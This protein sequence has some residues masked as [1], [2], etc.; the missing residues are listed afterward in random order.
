[1]AT[2]AS[3]TH[4]SKSLAN[5]D[6]MK[7][8]L[9]MKRLVSKDQSNSKNDTAEKGA[10]SKFYKENNFTPENNDAMSICS[11]K[12]KL[13]SI[14]SDST[15]NKSKKTSAQLSSEEKPS[16]KMF[17]NKQEKAFKQLAAIV[18]GFTLCF[19]PY[20]VVFLIVAMCEECI[21]EN[22]FTASVWLGY[23]N[24]TIN[25]FLYAI[26]NKRFF[27]KKSKQIQRTHTLTKTINH[28]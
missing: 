10:K 26:S 3:A 21:S 24:S 15:F 1:M 12:S 13:R 16:R 5:I 11:T 7:G 6:L 28:L 4:R 27:K 14:K 9:Q 18:I 8:A 25:P 2:T 22:V 19:L 17:M 23:L 20:F